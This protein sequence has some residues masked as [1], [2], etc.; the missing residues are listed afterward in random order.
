RRNERDATLA[1]LL[2]DRRLAWVVVLLSL[3][4]V[5][6]E[7]VVGIQHLWRETEL[8]DVLLE[9][10]TLLEAPVNGQLLWIERAV[11]ILVVRPEERHGKRG[12]EPIESGARHLVE[13]GR[14]GRGRR[15][16]RRHRRGLRR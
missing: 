2:L 6:D 4:L 1:E 9:R 3:G 10:C 14:G 7:T 16:S 13:L 12:G 11:L 15:R 5:F 8:A